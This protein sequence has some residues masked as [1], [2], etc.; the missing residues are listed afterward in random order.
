MQVPH[1]LNRTGFNLVYKGLGDGVHRHYPHSFVTGIKHANEWAFVK[2]GR[3]TDT[4][5]SIP[6]CFHVWVYEPSS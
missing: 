3:R 4:V 1:Q 5:K 2:D 6:S